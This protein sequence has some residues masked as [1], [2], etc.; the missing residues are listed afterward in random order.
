[1]TVLNPDGTVNY[2][3]TTSITD[4][5]A[6]TVRDASTGGTVVGKTVTVPI[7][8]S[9]DPNSN[10]GCFLTGGEVDCLWIALETQSAT[11]GM[12]VTRT[13]YLSGKTTTS[14]LTLP[15]SIAQSASPA[16][17][18]TNDSWTDGVVSVSCF[19][20]AGSL[21]LYAYNVNQPTQY[22]QID[23]SFIDSAVGNRLA[24]VTFPTTQ[25]TTY[26]VRVVELPFGGGSKPYLIGVVG[27]QNTVAPSAPLNLELDLSKPVQAGTLTITGPT[28][29]PVATVTTPA[30][31]D[32]SLRGLTW[33][34]PAGTPSGTYTWRLNVTDATGQAAVNN[35]G[36]GAPTG[37]FTIN[38]CTPFTDVPPTYLF[39]TSICWAYTNGITK[40]TG[41]GTTYSPTNPVNRGSMAAFLYRLAGSPA[42]KA[43]TV[44][45]FVDVATT[46]QFYS[47]ITW[48]YAHGITKGTMING[49]L[50][51]Q[52]GNA[53]NR[54]SMAAFMYRIAGNPTW[55]APTTPP[56]PDISGNQ[57]YT[58]I[59]WLAANGITTGSQVNGVTMYVPANA[60]NRGSMAAFMSRLATKHLIACTPYPHALGCT[61]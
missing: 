6:V 52:P 9:A 50:Y 4:S 25:D 14:S 12:W 8:P 1:V 40:G 34:P 49:Q 38:T 37:T 17:C 19:N 11:S 15:P 2:T 54:G 56:F 7:P 41:D 23:G 58:S 57:F 51:Y 22:V 32:G 46:N 28:G 47:S 24:V 44:S 30:S 55:S 60:V 13:D 31:T 10:A 27:D 53:V 45:P 3:Y 35:I 59:T 61:P 42:W 48:L 20:S 36:N 29:T 33:T 39:A 5:F 18:Y 43:P 21:G 26:S 16:S